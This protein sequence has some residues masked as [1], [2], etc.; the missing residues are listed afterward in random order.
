MC[1]SGGEFPL[2]I[3]QRQRSVGGKCFRLALLLFGE[4]EAW[5]LF[6]LSG[7]ILIFRGVGQGLYGN[8][9]HPSFLSFCCDR[10]SHGGSSQSAHFF[11][12]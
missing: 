6:Q 8:G 1:Q 7:P 3:V 10:V 9:L 4:L 5:T 2:I 11:S 12:L